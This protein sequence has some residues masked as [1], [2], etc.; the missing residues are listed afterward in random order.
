MKRRAFIAALAGAAAYPLAARAQQQMP[1]IGFLNTATPELF[2]DRLRAFR[3]GLKEG[4][5][6]E[7]ENVSVVSR[8]AENQFDRLPALADELVRRQVAV[9]CATGGSYSALAAKAATSK[10]PIVFVI[11]DDPVK[12]GLA[13]SL[14]R[15]GG[16]ATG[17]N[18]FATEVGA[19]RL[20][21]LRE[22]LPG[23]TRV[24]AFVNSAN[25]ARSQAVVDDLDVAARGMG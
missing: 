22:L 2:A 21:L 25:A 11:P 16:N 20:E 9:I 19:K 10:I 17:I 18:F 6:V 5:Y 23:V 1:A 3:Q 12:L 4:G 13:E 14:A 15:P 24:A 7:G 8:F